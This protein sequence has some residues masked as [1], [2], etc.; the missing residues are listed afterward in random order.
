M[1][2]L[3][4]HS[5]YTCAYLYLQS[6]RAWELRK[7]AS[8]LDCR[9]NVMSRWAV[10]AHRTKYL[11]TRLHSQLLHSQGQCVLDTE[12]NS[13]DDRSPEAMYTKGRLTTEEDR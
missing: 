12:Y 13:G 10:R 5:R 1:S 9:I 6:V 8:A 7:R 11:Y 2:I 3:A 4:G